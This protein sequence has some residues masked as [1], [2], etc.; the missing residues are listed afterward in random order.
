MKNIHSLIMIIRYMLKMILTSE[1]GYNQRD[2]LSIKQI[3]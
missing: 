2:V 3:I 1:Q